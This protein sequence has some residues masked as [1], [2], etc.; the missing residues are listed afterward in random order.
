MPSPSAPF[1]LVSQDKLCD[2]KADPGLLQV[3]VL[4]AQGNPMPGIEITI[5]WAEGADRFFTGFQPEISAGYADYTMTGGK[6]YSLQVAR[7]GVPVSG[8]AAPICTSPLA[9]TYLGG[10]QLTF[11]AP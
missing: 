5:T 11:S 10:M 7:M 8:I 9:Q 2:P 4:N 1:R 6:S 3:T